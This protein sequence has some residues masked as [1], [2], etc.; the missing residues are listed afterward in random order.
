MQE[1]RARD[2]YHMANQRYDMCQNVGT[3]YVALQD[4]FI[5]LQ[6]MLRARGASPEARSAEEAEI[7]A[8]LSSNLE[9]AQL[10]ERQIQ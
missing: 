6:G 3:Q 8:R 4:Q 9:S 1:T 5:E 10:S 2:A 7:F